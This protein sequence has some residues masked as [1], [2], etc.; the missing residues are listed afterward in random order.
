MAPH[1]GSGPPP[2]GPPS[3]THPAPPAAAPQPTSDTPV[4]P[5]RSACVLWHHP[6]APPPP[7]LIRS[8]ERHGAHITLCTN[9][10]EAL[11]HACTANRPGTRSPTRHASGA[12]AALLVVLVEPASLT[13]AAELVRALRRF[14]P[15]SVAWSYEARAQPALRAVSAGDLVRWDASPTA[16]GTA[17]QAPNQPISPQTPNPALGDPSAPNLRIDT[18][19]KPPTPRHAQP[20][21]L[22]LAGQDATRAPGSHQPRIE[23]K[24][25]P[26][27]GESDS[28][29]SSTPA[30][31]PPELPLPVPPVA[32]S[33]LL[34]PD[35]L[36]MLLS[37]DLDFEPGDSGP[38]PQQDEPPSPSSASPRAS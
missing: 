33:E 15:A 6:A 37:D 27:T 8:F 31:L 12:A 14:A 9:R 2:S 34:T 13:G 17:P 11:A 24:P 25:L 35:E 4:A 10:F 7:E 23:L 1:T 21:R 28:P 16:P 20:P 38:G 18:R 36:A 19:R 5:A 30:A 32:P 3:R 26:A 22:R 29:S